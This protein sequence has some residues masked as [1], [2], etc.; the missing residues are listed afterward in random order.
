MKK[1]STNMWGVELFCDVKFLVN[2]AEYRVV[3]YNDNGY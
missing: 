3:I 1:K 2:M